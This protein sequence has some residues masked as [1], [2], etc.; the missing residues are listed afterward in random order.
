MQIIIRSFIA[1]LCGSLL[2]TPLWAQTCNTTSIQESTPT[3]RF[4]PNDDGTVMDKETGITWMRCAIGQN[5]DGNTCAGNAN[6]YSWQDAVD[7]ATKANKSGY[8]GH[9]DWRLPYVP[10]LASIVERQCSNPRVNL[11]VFPATPLVAFW[12]GMEKMGRPD[13]AYILDFDKGNASPSV[14]TFKGAVRL[15][16]DG[17]NGPWWKMPDMH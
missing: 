5:W 1:I 3:S 10:E 7:T 17:P 9:T 8:G 6:T 13:M 16:H 4:N 15:M 14:K 12:T 11:K 2:A